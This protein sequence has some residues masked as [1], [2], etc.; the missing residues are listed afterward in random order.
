LAGANQLDTIGVSCSQFRPKASLPWNPIL[1]C[2]IKLAD[3]CH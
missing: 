3:E 2:M 1:S